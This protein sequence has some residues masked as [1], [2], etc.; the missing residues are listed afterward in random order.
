MWPCRAPPS[1]QRGPM[2]ISNEGARMLVLLAVTPG[3]LTLRT[4]SPTL[5][6][7]PPEAV[8]GSSSPW[9]TSQMPYRLVWSLCSP[10]VPSG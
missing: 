3:A 8:Q 9:A 1:E 2:V 6:Q 4:A 7:L 5:T 10:Q